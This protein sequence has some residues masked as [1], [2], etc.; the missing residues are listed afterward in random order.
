MKI[1][2]QRS[3]HN[4]FDENILL[5]VNVLQRSAHNIFDENIF[6]M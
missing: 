2:L 3:A 4:I 1:N 6:M 5:D